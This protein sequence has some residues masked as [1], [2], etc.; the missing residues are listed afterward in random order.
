VVWQSW[1]LILWQQV[2]SLLQALWFMG[3]LSP[4]CLFL[5][6]NGLGLPTVSLP[7]LVFSAVYL[8]LT[9][10]SGGHHRPHQSV[11]MQPVSPALFPC[12]ILWLRKN[13]NWTLGG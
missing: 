3:S 12:C 13:W 2:D 10:G 4:S 5:S 11:E 7:W 9:F 8:G 6:F 1:R